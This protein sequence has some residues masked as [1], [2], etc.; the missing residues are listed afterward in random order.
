[1]D[2][3]QKGKSL[4]EK[5]FLVKCPEQQRPERRERNSSES[6]TIRSGFLG[7]ARSVSRK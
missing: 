5:R 2:V 7:L 6:D 3:L 4:K 1:M